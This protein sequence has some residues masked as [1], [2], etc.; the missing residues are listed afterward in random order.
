[1]RHVNQSHYRLGGGLESCSW[2]AANESGWAMSISQAFKKKKKRSARKCDLLLLQ[3]FPKAGR[4]SFNK[5]CFGEDVGMLLPQAMKLSPSKHTP[6]PETEKCPGCCRIRDVRPVSSRWKMTRPLIK[7]SFT[8]PG[9]DCKL[10]EK[11][12]DT[13]NVGAAGRRA[14]HNLW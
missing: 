9:E 11:S 4:I 13:K 14:W 5:A 1:M 8:V 7:T 12:I 2:H 6:L 3:F 10:Q